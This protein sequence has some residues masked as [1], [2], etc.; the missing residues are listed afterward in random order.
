MGFVITALI[1]TA[2]S[3]LHFQQTIYAT[4]HARNDWYCTWSALNFESRLVYMFGPNILIHILNSY[5]CF[6]R[7]SNKMLSHLGVHAWN[8]PLT[9]FPFRLVFIS[10]TT[11]QHFFFVLKLFSVHELFSVDQ[12]QKEMKIVR[13]SGKDFNFVEVSL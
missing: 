6:T 13:I 9:V 1:L 5:T 7:I 3:K 4:M 2:T 10:S 11:S 8:I 12:I